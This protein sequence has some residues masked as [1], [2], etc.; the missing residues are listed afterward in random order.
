M[1]ERKKKSLVKFLLVLAVAVG[2][3]S[4]SLGELNMIASGIVIP[5]MKIIIIMLIKKSLP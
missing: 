5:Q 3:R 4:S 1:L 2:N